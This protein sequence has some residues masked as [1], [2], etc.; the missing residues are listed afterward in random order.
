MKNF[1]KTSMARIHSIETFGTVDGPGIRFVVFMQGCNLQ[2]KYCHNRDTWDTCGGHIVNVDDLVSKI[3]NYENYF[4]S[5]GGVTISGGEPLLQVKFLINLFKKLKEKNIHTAIDTSGMI[6]ITEDIKELISLTDLFLLDI[7]HINDEKCKE[8]VGFSNKKELEFAKYLSDNNKSMWIRQVL[9]PGITDNKDDLLEL[10][11]FI[12]SLK[13]LEKI[14]LLP[15]HS[16]GKYKWDKLGYKYE[17][18]EIPDATDED[19]KRAKEILRNI[20]FGGKHKA[21]PYMFSYIVN[22]HSCN[23]TPTITPIAYNK[24]TILVFSF[25]FLFTLNKTNIPN[26]AFTSNPASIVAILITFVKYNFVRITDDA[27]F[28][29]NPINPAIIGPNTGLFSIKFDKLSSPT[30]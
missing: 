14:E 9:I 20:N 16:I 8:L 3:E 5:S 12:N 13:T 29:I 24:T 18:E 21:C 26:P 28:G 2:C 30:K 4:I 25:M 1:D 23:T 15:Y 17:L 10:K 19:I 22:P 7:K 11:K 6:N 27:Q